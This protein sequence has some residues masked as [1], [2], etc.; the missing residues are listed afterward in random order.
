[1]TRVAARTDVARYEPLAIRGAAGDGAACKELVERLWPV[2]VKTV[3]ASRSLA[4][5]GASEDHVHNVVAKLVEKIGRADGRGLRLYPA[6]RERNPGKTFEDWIHIVTTNAVRDYVRAQ[7]GEIDAGTREP[8][9]KRLLNDFATS[10]LLDQ[11]GVRPP[12]T[13]AQ[14]A[15]QLLEYARTELPADQLQA[16]ALW[17]EGHAFE[18]IQAELRLEDAEAARKRV[19]AAVAAIRRKFGA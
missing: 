9:R 10:P 19:R 14:T 11:L 17:I 15:R 1:M 12:I 18:D 16:L 5:L 8:S 2:W 3:A 4:P 6:W 13:A 7:I